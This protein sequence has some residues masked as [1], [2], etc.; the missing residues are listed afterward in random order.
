M[1]IGDL[2]L[3]SASDLAVACIAL[4]LGYFSWLLF[5]DPTLVNPQIVA[6][7]AVPSAIG[8]KKAVEASSFWRRRDRARAVKAVLKMRSLVARNA[9]AQTD[10][11]ETGRTHLLAVSTTAS[12][13]LEM[14]KIVGRLPPVLCEELEELIDKVDHEN[15]A[16]AN[17]N[18]ALPL[19]Q[20]HELART[21]RITSLKAALVSMIDDARRSH[22]IGDHCAALE[23]L[24]ALVP[25]LTTEQIDA[26]LARIHRQLLDDKTLNLRPVAQLPSSEQLRAQQFAREL[27]AVEAAKQLDSG[28][29]SLRHS[30]GEV[31]T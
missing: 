1:K 12:G 16:E 22:S 5:G 28:E 11:M 4:P 25:E 20:R 26:E 14:R 24:N 2:D 19:S 3:D 8:V 21:S 15:R 29:A 23:R 7:L 9:W 10:L 6:G 17:A 31:A 13:L 27:D 18:N 30:R